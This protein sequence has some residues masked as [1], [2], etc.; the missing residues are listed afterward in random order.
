MKVKIGQLKTHLSEYL[1]EIQRT[2][3]PL[4]VCVRETVVAYLTPS[5]ATGSDS[6]RL[7]EAPMLEQHLKES[8]LLWKRSIL[9]SDDPFIPTPTPAGDGKRDISTVPAMRAERDW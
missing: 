8:G 6:V 1:R 9:P 7:A 2:G 4:E 3:E 5:S